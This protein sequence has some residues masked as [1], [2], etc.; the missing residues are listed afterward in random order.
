[1]KKKKVYNPNSTAETSKAQVGTRVEEEEKKRE[2]GR[3]RRRKKKKEIQ[4]IYRS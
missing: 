1:L 3:S 2:M 4:L